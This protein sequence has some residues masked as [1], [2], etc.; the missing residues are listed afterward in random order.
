MR[1]Y[2]ARHGESTGNAQQLIFGRRD[3]PL[4]EQG[5]AQARALGRSLEGARIERV[6]A[7]PLVRALETARIACPG[8]AIETDARLTEQ[9]MGRWEGMTEAEAL[10]D[11]APL[12][13]AMLSDWTR[14]QAAP[15]GGESYAALRARVS[16]ALGAILDRGANTLIVTHA[17]VL[18]AL[19]E[20]LLKTPRGQCAHEH[21]PCASAIALEIGR[22]GAARVAE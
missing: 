8:D 9:F 17:G 18:A 2:L 10:A 12:W 1:L 7:S 11:N 19:S 14:D 15:P 5:R 13:Q 16:Y 6:V 4:T 3:Y 22:D 20:L 21:F